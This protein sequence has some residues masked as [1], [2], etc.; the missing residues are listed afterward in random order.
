[1]TITTTNLVSVIQQNL[2]SLTTASTSIDI[3]TTS[4]AADL[5]D[6]A[7]INTY[8]TLADFP[9]A[10]IANRGNIAFAQDAGVQYVN[11]S[12]SQWTVL[13]PV[14]AIS[15][16]ANPN[17]IVS[18]GL[19]NKLYTNANALLAVATANFGTSP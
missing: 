10:T 3:L 15:L 19:L 4:I 8:P 1:M 6:T 16:S 13:L 14:P 9:T 5:T 7:K 18:N 12:G 11:V 17:D 2:D